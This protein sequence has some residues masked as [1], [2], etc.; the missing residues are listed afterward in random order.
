M[1]NNE[2]IAAISTPLGQGGIG[3]VRLS[4]KDSFKIADKIFEH[5]KGEGILST[6]SH[7]VH[8]GC[9]KDPDEGKIVDEALLTVMHAPKTYTAEDIVELSCHGGIIPLK[10]VLELCVSEGA[11]LAEP[12]E[13]TK[14]AFLNGRLDLAQAEA[15]L[16]IIKAR[17]DASC[18]I[19]VDHL[20]GRFS[21]KIQDLREKLAEVLSSIELGIDFSDEDVEL[22]AISEI[23][24][25]IGKIAEALEG[26]LS[27]YDKGMIIKEGVRAVICGRPNVGKSSLMNSLLGRDRVIVTPVAGTT[28]DVVE[29]S[30]NVSGILIKLSDTAGII[31]TKDRVEI[32]GIK[33][34]KEKLDEADIV[35]FM[36]DASQLLSEKD[37]KIFNAVSKKKILVIANKIDLPKEMDIKEAREKFNN[38]EILEI[39]VLKGEGIEKI[40]S[41]ISRKITEKNIDAAEGAIVANL[42][43]KKLLEKAHENIKRSLENSEQNYNGELIASDLND[44]LH[45]LGLIIGESIEDDVLDRIFSQFCIGK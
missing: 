13:F 16:D 19:A 32:E 6:P 39:S 34:S 26:L 25:N 38:E 44:A 9:I 33:R 4:G 10:R 8:Y 21:K 35:L 42:R 37:E 7:T 11:R 20:R 30:I 23:R 18:S 41:A 43:H 40:E 31:E 1:K 45:H 5:S 29:E 17:T 3:V 27:T 14:R 22:K 2:T 24:R 15:V 28:R 36:L 12:G